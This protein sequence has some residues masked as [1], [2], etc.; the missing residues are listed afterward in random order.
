MDISLSEA[1]EVGEKRN[2]LGEANHD[3]REESYD[4]VDLESNNELSM[5]VRNRKDSALGWKK[6]AVQLDY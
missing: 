1:Q 5:P 6:W 3:V 4:E 2:N